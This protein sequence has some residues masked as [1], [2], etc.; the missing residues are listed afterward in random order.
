MSSEFSNYPLSTYYFAGAILILVVIV[1]YLASEHAAH[2]VYRKFIEGYW[3]ASAAFCERSGIESAQAYFR[4]GK[5]YLLIAESDHIALNKCVDVSLS[6]TWW[7]DS[8]HVTFGEDVAPLPQECE[9]RLDGT[10]MGLFQDDTLYLELFKN[11]K[12]SAGVV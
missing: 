6:P 10:M 9:L 3:D 12:A 11:S 4:D 8:W 1:Y 7:S 2:G 5:V